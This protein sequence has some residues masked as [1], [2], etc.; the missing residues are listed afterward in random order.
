[1]SALAHFFESEGLATTTIALIRQHA[2]RI[3]PPRALWVPFELGRPFGPPGNTTFQ[4]RVIKSTLALLDREEGPVVLE[5]FPDE[6]PG[7]SDDPQWLLPAAN[8]T[9]SL[10]AEVRSLVPANEEFVARN[11]FSNVGLTR[12]PIETIAEFIARVD[13][14]DPM[15][16]P[17]RN[18]APIQI[19]RYGADDLKAYYAEAA[20]ARGGE[21]S[22]RQIWGW[23]WRKTLAG[24]ALLEIREASVGSD[25][26]SR[27]GIQRSLVPELWLE[28]EEVLTRSR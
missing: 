1:M 8:H 12:L 24:A 19:L 26:K 25:D 11:G 17:T 23:F 5:D 15:L 20:A 14:E 27:Q 22:S 2:E 21:P 13:S 3:Q 4:R 9:E 18:L 7:E 6:A 10:V 16:R 28:D